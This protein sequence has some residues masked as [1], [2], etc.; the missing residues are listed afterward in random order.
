MLSRS[1]DQSPT[2]RHRLRLR[3]R[4]ECKI[5]D[6]LNGRRVIA[7]SMSAVDGS[8][9]RLCWANKKGVLPKQHAFGLANW[10]VS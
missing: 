2:M 8:M 10:F 3:M 7:G 1:I 5:A 9:L 6:L 4:L